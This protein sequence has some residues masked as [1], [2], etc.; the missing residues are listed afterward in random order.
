MRARRFGRVGCVGGDERDVNGD[1]CGRLP[2]VSEIGFQPCELLWIDERLPHAVVGR[3]DGVEDDEVPAFVVEGVV[4]FAEA[5]FVHFFRVAG[6]GG[7]DAA[8]GGDTEDVVIADGVMKRHAEG[9]FGRLIEVE[10]RVGSVAIDGV[11]VE[12]VVAAHDG[13]VGI[14]RGDFAEGHVAAVAGVEFGLDV[15]VGKE[16]EVEVGRCG[17]VGGCDKRWV[18]ACGGG[19]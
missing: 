19:G 13:E 7:G 9:L 10:Y 3:L 16:D 18:D 4:S 8:G 14:E 1:D 12:D 2:G 15:G 11:G 6:V 17:S 5:V